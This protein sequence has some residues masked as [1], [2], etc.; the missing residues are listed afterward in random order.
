MHT[1]KKHC[2]KIHNKHS[3]KIEIFTVCPVHAQHWTK[4]KI[5]LMCPFSVPEIFI[6]D[7]YGTKNW[8]QKLA[9]ENGVDLWCRFLERVS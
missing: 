6:R 8:R 3:S 2:T 7:I 1:T 9:P 4:Y 5:T